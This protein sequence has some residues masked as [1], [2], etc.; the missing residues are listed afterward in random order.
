MSSSDSTN[1]VSTTSPTGY[2]NEQLVYAEVQL[3]RPLLKA[4][5]ESL[6]KSFRVAQKLLEKEMT[7]LVNSINDLN[8]KKSS[9]SPEDAK[10]TI[11][12]LLTKMNNLK[13]KIEETKDEEEV[14][15]KRMKSRIT[16]LKHTCEN[17]SDHYIKE[18]FNNKRVDRVIIDHLLR[19]GFYD[20]AIKLATTSNI[21]EFIELVR[22][23]KLGP[24]ISYARQHL[25]PNASTNMPEIQA[26]MATLAFKKDQQCSK[27]RPLFQEERWN[28]LIQQFK[29]DN[30][31]LHSLT[32]HSLLNIS[33][34]S[35]LSVLKTEQCEDEETKNINCPLCDED[36]QSLAEPLPVSLQSHSSLICKIT[37][38][39]MDEDN[40]PM[41]LPNGNVYCKNAMLTMATEYNNQITDPKSGNK[42]DY[43]ELRRAFI[44]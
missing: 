30:Y 40:P 41:V 42:Y 36:F 19:E 6:N 12:K 32:H 9:I 25:A 28:D 21:T 15:I 7:Q 33:L 20:T 5:I 14:Q 22:Q 13:R 4:P 8:K 17:H 31:N 11:E 38:E 27:Y 39:I 16:H 23:T 43:S 3:E 1:N 26:A 24:A 37:G 10:N 18:E 29:S 35:G 34:Q 2:V 44:S